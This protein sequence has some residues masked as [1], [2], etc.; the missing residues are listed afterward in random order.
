M[1]TP[2]IAQIIEREHAKAARNFGAP[3]DDTYGLGPEHVL[4]E[5]D[6]VESDEY[7]E[8]VLGEDDAVESDECPEHF[9]GED[10]AVESDE[11]ETRL[12]RSEKGKLLPAYENAAVFFENSPE[13]AGVLGYNE[14]TGGYHILQLPPSPVTSVVGTEIQDHFDAEAVR[15][16]ERRGL[17]VKPDLVRHV[18]DSVARRNSYHPVREYLGSLPPWDGKPRIRTWL[19]DYCNVASSDAN[20]NQYAMVVGEKF[21]IAAIARIWAPGCKQDHMLVLEGSQGIGKSS[22]VR[23][24]AG[25]WFTDQLADPGSKDAS[26]Q[27][28][29]A[30]LIELNE[31]AALGRTEM[32]RTKAF[33][34]QQV[35]RFRLPYGHRL[36][37]MPRQ[38]VF[39]GTTNSETW[40]KDETGGRRFW[41]VRCG[42]PIDLAGLQRDRDQLWAEALLRY[43]QKATW[44]LDDPQVIEDAVDQQRSRY[45]EDVWQER[46]VAYAIE[47]AQ[48]STS[49]CPDGRGSVSIPAILNRLGVETPKQDQ[50]AANRVARCLQIAQ[51][52][53]F[54]RRE[55]AVLAWRYRKAEPK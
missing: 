42:T 52:E 36:V 45:Q 20:P 31:L 24:L 33:I 5:D 6:A 47:E 10:D 15:W 17:M 28:R 41:P 12:L 1:T 25:E 50:A 44:W 53:R 32:E 37:Q 4:A 48:R 7:P 49:A 3:G 35:E 46:V 43:L 16:L 11:W 34:T 54:R 22:V 30:W 39:I 9:L 40:L 19:L 18:V 27:L 29:G 51:W 8:H 26:M 2:D 23:I 14:F 38:C 55:G 21:L 13:W